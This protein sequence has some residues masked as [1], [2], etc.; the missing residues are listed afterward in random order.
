MAYS[1]E[2]YDRSSASHWVSTASNPPIGEKGKSHG[3]N[4]KIASGRNHDNVT[5]ADDIYHI[6]DIRI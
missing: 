6:A 3:D 2:P 4:T 5:K 1:R